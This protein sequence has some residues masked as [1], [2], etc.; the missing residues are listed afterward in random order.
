MGYLYSV[1]SRVVDT[2]VLFI[3]FSRARTIERAHS[4]KMGLCFIAEAR[5]Y[6]L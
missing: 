2:S 6:V 4:K 3:L 5:L 1:S